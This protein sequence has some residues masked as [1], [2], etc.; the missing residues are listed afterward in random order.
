MIW[1]NLDA[2]IPDGSARIGRAIGVVSAR[3]LQVLCV[4][5]LCFVLRVS[6]P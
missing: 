3:Y 5:G 2:K 4:P 6:G 1:F